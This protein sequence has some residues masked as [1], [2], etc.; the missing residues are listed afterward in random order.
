ME[1]GRGELL[2]QVELYLMKDNV[3]S[4]KLSKENMLLSEIVIFAVLVIM[5]LPQ[6]VCRIGRA[7]CSISDPLPF[8]YK[9]YQSGDFIV[10]NM[11]SQIYVF[12][13]MMDF[14]K[15][16]SKELFEDT[17]V[18][19]P[20]YQHILALEFAIKEI[21]RNLHL[22]PNH[23]L[24]FQI[25]NTYFMTS[26]TYRASLELFSTKGQFI[27]NYNCDTQHRPIAVLGGPTT[28]VCLHMA[29]ILSLYKMPQIMY[30]ST[31]EG[32]MKKEAVLYQQMFP[33]MD[34]QYK[35]IFLLLLHFRWTW[36][37]ILSLKN[38]SGEK[39]IQDLV[40]M[41]AQKGICSDFIET[42][43]IIDD[44]SSIAELVEMGLEMYMV[45]M[46]STVNIVLVH[47]EIYGIIVLRLLSTN[48]K[49][50]DAS[51]WRKSKIWVMT[52]EMD[53]TSLPFLR[54]SDL[55]FLHG[56]LSF[57][58]H[59]EKVSGFQKFVQMK[60]PIL[61]KEDTF[62]KLFWESAFECSFS[63]SEVEVEN[64]I[65]CTGKE[66]LLALPTSVFEMD[67]TGHSYSIYDAIHVVAYALHDFHSSMLQ[68]RAR[69]HEA[70][71]ELLDQKL[72]K[73]NKF[74]KGVSFNNSAEQKVSFNQNGE[75]ETGFDIM[76][77]IT[78]SNLS[79]LRVTVGR[80]DPKDS[81]ESLF[82]INEDDIV[83]PER[84][85]QVQP[86][87][88]CNSKCHSGYTRSK[89]E[90]KPFCCYDCLQCPHGKISNQ[91]DMDDC[92]PCPKAQYA[93]VNQDLCLSKIATFLM[94]EEILGIILA[95]SAVF[96]S[97]VTSGILWIFIKHQDTPIV[98]ANNRNLTYALL[99]ALLLSFLSSL[100]FLG[101]PDKVTCL[102]R[103]TTFGIIFSVA[104]SCVL[105]KT[106]IVILAFMATKPGS[107]MIRWVGRRV[108][109]SI[110]L[111]CTL[112]QGFICTIWLTISPP[113]PDA[114]TSSGS[115]EIFLECNEGSV[116]MF[117][118]VLG[119]MGF[120]AIISF[121]VAFLA[122][123]LPD[124]FNEAKFI[125]FSMLVFCS[126][127]LSFVPTYLSTKGKYMVAVEIFSI[128][129]SSVGLLVCIFFPKCYIIVLKPSLN[130]KEQLRRQT[131]IKL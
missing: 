35:G 65:P 29:T 118:C 48:L 10:V 73:L 105:A 111:C 72:W 82:T 45:V 81:Q 12:H 99:I 77:W 128:I 114:D 126:V 76:N 74:M 123:K 90:G 28:E 119:Y 104:I 98:K 60:D 3:G 62:I 89:I 37:G 117:Y 68:H 21:N 50:E 20:I 78:F 49:T 67:M 27:P 32:S 122:R 88:L 17:V 97:L 130:N 22:L 16:P 79:F 110:L 106:V 24:G 1:E 71:L 93:N 19:T 113:F 125:T 58:I 80:M 109:V 107:K 112:L 92:F 53:F 31:I 124:V 116:Y 41:L 55:V 43:P 115:E 64:V 46:K 13:A 8:L 87:S 86:L 2:T 26:W 103:Q 129:A 40:P 51:L 66:K 9:H 52:A 33:S 44:S 36:I 7:K 121:T 101:K 14:S 42:F 25:Y 108:A 63:I 85:N 56:A 91:I 95:S 131:H 75:L 70:K 57:A 39:F 11:L 15:H 54:N 100:L 84:F 47:G 4:E 5:P 94:Y 38:D 120:L 69:G 6:M 23:T 18:M 102:L 83:W 59:T 30:G 61:E 96:F 127:W 34:H